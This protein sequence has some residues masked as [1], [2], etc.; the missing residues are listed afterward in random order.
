MIKINYVGLRLQKFKVSCPDVR[1][2]MLLG[3]FGN[4]LNEPDFD[5]E[6]H[7]FNELYTANVLSAESTDECLQTNPKTTSSNLNRLESVTK[8]FCFH[9]I[10]K[11]LCC[12][13]GPFVTLSD[14]TCDSSLYWVHSLDKT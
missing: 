4:D 7:N 2:A 8:I 14:V 5:S 10:S 9:A 13:R 11:D 1:L 3:T 12:F 6:F